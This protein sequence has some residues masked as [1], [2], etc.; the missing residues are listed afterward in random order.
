MDNCD[1]NWQMWLQ[2][3]SADRSS[4]IFDIWEKKMR[5]FRMRDWLSWRLLVKAARLAIP[6]SWE[7]KSDHERAT[8]LVVEIM[9]K[10][11]GRFFL[12][13]FFKKIEKS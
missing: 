13:L 8:T 3:A 12:L 11:K 1:G 10:Q 2:F 4:L 6:L 9:E 7:P 5:E